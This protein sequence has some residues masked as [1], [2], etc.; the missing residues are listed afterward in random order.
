MGPEWIVIGVAV[1]TLL[2]G[3]AA[4]AFGASR[5]GSRFQDAMEA[6]WRAVAETIGG[7]LEVVARPTLAPRVL[8]LVVDLG[9]VEAVAWLRVPVDPGAPS[10]TETQARYVLGVGPTFEGLE[11]DLSREAR[12]LVK[13]IPRHL[14][15]RASDHVVR[16]VWDGA[17]TDGTVLA[18]ALKLVA[19]VARH[20]ADH[21]RGLGTIDDAVY[22]S[23][24]EEGARVRVRRGLAEIRILVLI[25]GRRELL[26]HVA[27]TRA[28]VPRFHAPVSPDGSVGDLP[29]GV[30]G[31]GAAS[32]VDKVMPASFRSDGET[33]EIVWPDPPTLDQVEAAVR[34]LAAVGT[35]LGSGGAFR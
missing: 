26:V 7:R 29:E 24:S 16:V 21:L 30:V 5:R 14:T 33:L 34:I 32:E 15:L 13:A 2:A 8:R 23:E 27:R 17:E 18:D 12:S 35:S 3:V 11:Q 31:P 19:A 9:D 4:A 25:E 20:G 6:R 1:S 10:Y 28:S 22:E